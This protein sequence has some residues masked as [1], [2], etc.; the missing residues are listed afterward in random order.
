MIFKQGTFDFGNESRDGGQLTHRN[1]MRRNF[2]EDKVIVKDDYF[3]RTF[4]EKYWGGVH[5]CIHIHD[6][7]LVLI[8]GLFWDVQLFGIFFK[9]H[10]TS[11]LVNF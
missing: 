8:R 7:D 11:F 3:F 1:I 2:R 4:L 10:I 6:H 5:V 9:S